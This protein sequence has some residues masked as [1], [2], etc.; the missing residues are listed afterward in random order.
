MKR[1]GYS[2]V[3][4]EAIY[5]EL[6]VRDPLD[7]APGAVDFIR[8]LNAKGTGVAIATASGLE[9]VEFYLSFLSSANW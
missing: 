8:F 2:F 5:R 1:L 9:N 6:F 3:E 4:K 7:F